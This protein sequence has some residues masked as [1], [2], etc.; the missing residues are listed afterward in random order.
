MPDLLGA[1]FTPAQAGWI[2]IY[3]SVI[4]TIL[5]FCA[6]PIVH[7]FSSIGLLV[8]SAVVAIVGL[9]FLS[10]AAG[11]AI[12]VAATVY[13]F[14]K[15]FLWSTTL[16]LVAEQFPKGGALTL[17]GV[18][19]VGVLGMGILGTPIMGGLQDQGI[20]ADLEKTTRPFTRRSQAPPVMFR[21]SVK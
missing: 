18:S 16:G 4:M 12:I 21:F 17:N 1:D 19:A 8:I 14:G 2:F 5:R 9:M 7:K 11:I 13:A 6:G 20:N 10:K 15:T 3:V